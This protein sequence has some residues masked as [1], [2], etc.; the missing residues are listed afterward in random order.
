MHVF[1]LCVYE[2]VDIEY[3]CGYIVFTDMYIFLCKSA[4]GCAQTAK[5]V[6]GKRGL[7]DREE[8]ELR[9]GER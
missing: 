5:Y 2:C 7:C 1:I 3:E 8:R 9:K 6:V 4:D